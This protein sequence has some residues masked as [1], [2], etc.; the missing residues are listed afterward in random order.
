MI[1]MLQH[2]TRNSYRRNTA[3]TRVKNVFPMSY[4]CLLY[5]RTSKET[6]KGNPQTSDN[7]ALNT[8]RRIYTNH[9]SSLYVPL[10]SSFVILP[11]LNH[12]LL[13]T[14]TPYHLTSQHFFLPPHPILI[15]RY[16]LHI[17]ISSSRATWTCL[18]ASYLSDRI[19]P[20]FCIFLLIALK[21]IIFISDSPRA[22]TVSPPWFQ[23]PPW[24]F[25]NFPDFRG[26]SW[27]KYWD[28]VTDQR[29]WR[30]PKSFDHTLRIER[31]NVANF[32]I[33]RNLPLAPPGTHDIHRYLLQ[34]VVLLVVL[35]A[36]LQPQCLTAKHDVWDD[37][38]SS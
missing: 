6:R 9:H 30:V 18:P 8:F 35:V 5:K 3:G 34:E 2:W 10:E 7:L 12:L 23:G 33:L 28:P 22:M 13:M 14:T 27:G 19:L 16:Y 21:N 1:L 17:I 29:A 11:T 24:F 36:D 26:Y 38:S 31:D 4:H 32:N 37:S 20:H 15:T 25:P